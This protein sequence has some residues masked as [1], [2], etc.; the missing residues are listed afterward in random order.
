MS[1]RPIALLTDFGHRDPFVGICHG[2]IL[3]ADPAI[4]R[5]D[6]T[7]GIKRQDVRA[8]ALALADAA[9]YMPGDCVFL[10]I[11]DPGVGGARRAVAIEAGDGTLFV[12]PDNGLLFAAVTLRGG[13]SRAFEIS[14]S[15][16]RL[17]P[18]SNTFH[19]RDV[20]APVAAQLATG[21]PIEQCGDELD[22]SE[23]HRLPEPRIEW[24][25]DGV[26]TSVIAI[27]EFGNVR[28]A[29]HFSDL[30][31]VYRGDRLMVSAHG[32]SKAARAA[33]AYADGNDNSLLLIEDST[34]S[35]TLAI[36]EGDAAGELGVQ[37]G[38]GVRI[39]RQ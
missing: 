12:G 36:N 21:T 18:V 22:S 29:G 6:I 11:V 28:L 24:S 25:G 1:P 35:L 31:K 8:G 15:D 33:S 23:L 27:D 34:G 3:R 39:V 17:E 14:N 20:F 13:A 38:D 37:T 30:G 26:S 2:V 5:I 4:A 19:G 9:P 7:H 16:W 32:H 10:A